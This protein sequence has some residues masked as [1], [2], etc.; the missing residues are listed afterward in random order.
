L[1]FGL[2]I[3]SYSI[4]L[5]LANIE[6]TFVWWYQ[7][8]KQL[9]DEKTAWSGATMIVG[10]TVAMAHMWKLNQDRKQYLEKRERDR[11]ERYR[12]QLNP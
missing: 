9:V 5:H 11:R 1:V 6:F 10:A 7:L 12:R 3:L 8:G 4:H 2:F